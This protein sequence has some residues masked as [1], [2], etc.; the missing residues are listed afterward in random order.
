MLPGN[1]ESWMN[2]KFAIHA[3]A[4]VGRTRS[5]ERSRAAAGPAQMGNALE[6]LRVATTF[7]VL[8]YHASLAYLATPMRL[9]LWVAYDASG[10]VA[11]DYFVYWVNGFAM[12][13]F[14]L[15]AGVSAPAACAS[16]GP[17][18]FLTSRVR[19]LLRPLLF[20]CLTIL[21]FSYLVWGYGL[22][23]TG[24]I[25]LERSCGGGSAP[26]FLIISM[27]WGISGSS[28]ISSWSACSG[29]ADGRS[30][31]P[32]PS[33]GGEGMLSRRAGWLGPAAPRL[34][35]AAALA[36]GPDRPDL[37]HRFGHDA[38]GGQPDRPEPLPVAPLRLFLH[39]RRL[40]L[41]DPRP[42]AALIPYST[43]YLVLSFVLFALMSPL[44]LRHAAVPLE[45]RAGSSTA[46]S[47]P[48]SPG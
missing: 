37:L 30:E 3:P 31:L 40:D 36:R 39:R 48:C 21:P 22:M 10:H 29:V 17:R 15:A 4:K 35:V 25:E 28:N 46:C 41:E 34:A 9:T 19:R 5:P 18:V 12:P 23:V 6:A 32:V 20:A 1:D 7:F 42:P 14:F 44:L 45:G 24:G 47:P 13:V 43:L 16:R 11:F 27:A 38:P 33:R 2:P 8:L 26:R